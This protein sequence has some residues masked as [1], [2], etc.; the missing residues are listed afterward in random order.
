MLYW[1]L[2][3]TKEF[4]MEKV[5]HMSNYINVITSFITMVQFEAKREERRSSELPPVHIIPWQKF[6]IYLKK[7]PL[8]KI[9]DN[10]NGAKFDGPQTSEG[11]QINALVE[12]INSTSSGDEFKTSINTIQKILH[13]ESCNSKNMFFPGDKYTPTALTQRELA[14]A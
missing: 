11:R 3:S 6:Q 10:Y 1:A 9:T 8:P 7:N 2:F 4:L 5:H 12:V 13:G 14:R